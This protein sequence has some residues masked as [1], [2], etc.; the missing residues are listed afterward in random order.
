MA[1][2]RKRIMGPRSNAFKKRKSTF[3]RKSK[4]VPKYTNYKSLST[5]GAVAGFRGRKTSRRA[6]RKH[7]WNSS[8]FATKYRS[9]ASFGSTVTTAASTTLGTVT[10]FNLLRF[11]TNAFWTTAG[12]LQPHDFG[13]TSAI[14]GGNLI[15]RGGIWNVEFKNLATTD[16]DVKIRVFLLTSVNKPDF[17]FEPTTA[18]HLWDPTASADFIN[19]IGKPFKT[20]E[21]VLE[22]GNS[23]EIGGRL[24]MQSVDQ[25]TYRE[26]GRTPILVVLMTNVGTSTANSVHVTRSYNM[27]FAG[28]TQ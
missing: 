12:G 2:K 19:F 26:Q 15:V 28:D 8:L 9:L 18:S 24:R 5:A 27:L 10:L 7:L 22:Q 23:W 4:R 3:R 14:F 1:F 21:T 13:A 17:T 11:G 25:I 6:Y 16:L 20:W